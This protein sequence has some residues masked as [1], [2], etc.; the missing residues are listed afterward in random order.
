MTMPLIHFKN[1][2]IDGTLKKPYKTLL[3]QM[4]GSA[5][6]ERPHSLGQHMHF[7]KVYQT[8]HVRFVA[9]MGEFHV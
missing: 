4:S 6:P 8:V 7:F 9:I 5:I 1:D 3:T 2:I